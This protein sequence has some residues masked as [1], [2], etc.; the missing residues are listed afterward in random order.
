M[1]LIILNIQCMSVALQTDSTLIQTSVARILMVNCWKIPLTWS[2]VCRLYGGYSQSGISSYSLR[3][4]QVI[5]ASENFVSLNVSLPKHSDSYRPTA[6]PCSPSSYFR[7]RGFSFAKAYGVC[8]FDTCPRSFALHFLQRYSIYLS[9]VYS[10]DAF[11]I[12]R[13]L[14]FLV[15]SMILSAYQSLL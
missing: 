11:F 10:N 8:T 4:F 6:T 14:S 7:Y 12:Q 2:L 15:C 3:S 1:K 5:F 9:Q 13:K